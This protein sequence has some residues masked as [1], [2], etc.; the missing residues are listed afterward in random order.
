MLGR[1]LRARLA[2]SGHVTE[3]VS[4]GG[5]GQTRSC[6][7][8]VKSRVEELFRSGGFDAVIHAAAYSDVDGCERDPER[9]HG[10]N[11]LATAHLAEACGD[12]IPLVHVSTDYVFSGLQSNPYRESDATCPI[13]IYGLTKLEGEFFARRA[14]R[15]A[16]VRTS[17]LFGPGNPAN[18]VN[19]IIARLKS[20]SVVRVLKDQV[21]CPTYVGDL[22]EALER[23]L[24]RICGLSAAAEVFHFCN[25]GATTRYDMTQFIRDCMALTRVSVETLSAS[26]VPNRVALRPPRPVL[27]TTNYEKVFGTRVRRWQDSLKDYL[28]R[29]SLCAC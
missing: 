17:W 16:I 13:N 1:A 18:F 22:S 7:L 3:G 29:E 23:V 27:S 10:A 21:D 20:E 19:A 6:D 28:K 5:D 15:S 11:A 25:A 8:S 14:K 26:D 12:R 4:R 2:E 9:A 24:L